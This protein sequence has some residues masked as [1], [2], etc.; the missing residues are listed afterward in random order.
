M[1]TGAP[2]N[3]HRRSGRAAL[4]ALLLITGVSALG[5]GV[6]GLSGADAVPREWLSGTPFRTYFVPSLVLIIVVGGTQLAAAAAVVRG[7]SAARVA[8]QVATAVLFAWI[9]IQVSVI[10]YV[11]F[12]QPAMASVAVTC[13]LL[14][15]RVYG[16]RA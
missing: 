11:S 5:G 2:G 8:A 6:Y 16:A 1:T 7:A 10:G 13:S 9:V 15:A 3:R 14:T 12:L 4:A